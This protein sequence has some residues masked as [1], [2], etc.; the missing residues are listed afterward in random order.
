MRPPERSGPVPWQG[1]TSSPG[2]AASGQAA[3][4]RSVRTVFSISDGRY[5]SIT[6]AGEC[7]DEARI[8]R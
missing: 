2:G 4:L 1:E 8:F 5:K 6:S 3:V 7:L